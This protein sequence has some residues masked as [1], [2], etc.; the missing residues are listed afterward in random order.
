MYLLLRPVIFC[1]PAASHL[2]G[3]ADGSHPCM[4]AACCAHTH[5][6]TQQP[7]GSE[8][9]RRPAKTCRFWHS[10]ED[11]PGVDVLGVGPHE[12]AKGALVRDLAHPLDRAY[13]RWR[14]WTASAL[15]QDFKATAG[16]LPTVQTGVRCSRRA[17]HGRTW[18]SVRRSGDRPPCT[19][20]TRPSMSACRSATW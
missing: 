6:G 2:Q 18:S 16:W 13:L 15:F 12:V 7:L 8:E 11:T 3:A 1:P 5:M 20:S 17:Q 19:H 10:S 9:H 4:W 14:E